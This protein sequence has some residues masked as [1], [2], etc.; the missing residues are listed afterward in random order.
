MLMPSPVLTFRGLWLLRAYTTKGDG[1]HAPVLSVASRM[2]FWN[3]STISMLMCVPLPYFSHGTRDDEFRSIIYVFLSNDAN[4]GHVVSLAQAA[5]EQSGI[6]FEPTCPDD[7]AQCLC[8]R[9]RHS[10]RAWYARP[11]YDVALY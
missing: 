8:W 6:T 9:S 4:N 3:V 10:G 1:A 11:S 7:A 2:L 5:R